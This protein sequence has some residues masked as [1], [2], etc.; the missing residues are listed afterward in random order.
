M[1]MSEGRKNL[2]NWIKSLPIK[3]KLF[4]SIFIGIGIIILLYQFNWS[5]FGRDSNKSVTIK[6]VI[7]PKD[8]IK[9]AKN[10]EKAKYNDD[11]RA[12]LGLPPGNS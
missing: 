10:W 1:Y 12:K 5:G 4:I 9:S 2:A 8:R 11:F 3:Q 7:N 6:E